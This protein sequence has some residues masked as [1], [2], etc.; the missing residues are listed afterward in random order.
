[1]ARTPEE[2]GMPLL[3]VPYTPNRYE[4]FVLANRRI[5]FDQMAYLRLKVPKHSRLHS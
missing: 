3:F 1:M 4:F 2:A 5:L